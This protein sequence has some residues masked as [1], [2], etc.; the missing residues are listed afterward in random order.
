MKTYKKIKERLEKHDVIFIIPIIAIAVSIFTLRAKFD[1]YDELW[2]LSNIYK[3]YNGGLIYRD[4]NVIITPLF[5]YI[6]NIIFKLIGANYLS[7]RIYN[8]IIYTALIT[9]IYVLFKKLKLSKGISLF[10]TIITFILMISIIH[11][12]ANYNVMA[13]VFAICGLIIEIS[14]K[15]QNTKSILQGIIIFL[16]FFTKQNIGV[17]YIIGLI[18]YH[19]MEN[20]ENKNIK[21]TIIKIF[22]ELAVAFILLLISLIY[23]YFRGNLR[24][25]INYAFLGMKEFTRNFAVGTIYYII[26]CIV[27][28]IFIILFKI[29]IDKILGIKV[30]KNANIILVIGITF[31]AIQYP[32]FNEYHY[33]TS[34]IVISV[35]ILYIFD[36]FLVK[37]V[38]PK[39]I[40]KIITITN[41]INTICIL[42]AL[43]IGIPSII[44]YYNKLQKENIPYSDIYYGANMSEEQEKDIEQICTYIIDQKNNGINVKIISYRAMTYMTPL[45]INNGVFDLVFLGNL[46]I[47]GED[48]IIEKIKELQNTQILITKNEEDKIYQESKKVREYIMENLGNCGS[49]GDFLI[50]KSANYN[51]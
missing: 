26:N 34:I 8:I 24:Y 3:M 51:K 2:N 4:C 9:L 17:Y 16:I 27:Q 49:I 43:V 40:K 5:F 46:G 31:I 48:G 36:D 23:M 29:I 22:S 12:G 25:F 32:I 41:T 50:Y 42:L 6:G 39:I 30:E 10:S 14:N 1:T 28:I 45:K 38:P 7:F 35:Y 15:K 18:I 13:I 20:H 19:I 11:T 33:I 44:L 37:I 47:H 21:N